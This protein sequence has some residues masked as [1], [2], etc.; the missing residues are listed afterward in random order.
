MWRRTFLSDHRIAH[1]FEHPTS[2]PHTIPYN[3][4]Y[5]YQ[6]Y[7]KSSYPIE[8]HESNQPEIVSPPSD[9]SISE[10]LNAFSQLELRMRVKR[11]EKE[12]EREKQNIEQ[13][14][15][16]EQTKEYVSTETAGMDAFLAMERKLAGKKLSKLSNFSNSINPSSPNDSIP[17]MCAVLVPPSPPGP[18]E[19]CGMGCPNCIWIQYSQQLDEFEQN[20]KKINSNNQTNP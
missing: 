19:C 4:T 15:E 5:K 14:M 11:L 2:P 1:L 17:N 16:R 3:H 10:G 20:I 18:G 9:V 13:K 12:R 8:S 6:K 7:P